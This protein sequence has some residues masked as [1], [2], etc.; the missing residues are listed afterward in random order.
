MWTLLEK[1]SFR[2]RLQIDTD[3]TSTVYSRYSGHLYSG[4]SDIVA[5]FPCTKSIYS[6]IF[7]SDIVAN[8]I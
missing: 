1:D 7:R 6:I 2:K 3:L 5:S 4:N 8:R